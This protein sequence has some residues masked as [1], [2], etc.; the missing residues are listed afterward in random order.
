MSRIEATPAAPTAAPPH[1]SSDSLWLYALF[2]LLATAGFFYVNIMAAIVDGLVTGLGFSNAQAGI[3][4]SANIYGASVGSLIAVFI[5]RHLPWRRT[6][7]V[8]LCLLLCIDLISIAI[9][10][11]TLLTVVRALHGLI[12][13]MAVGVTYS[14]MARTRSPDRA[15][16][17]LLLMQFGLG[18]L[19]VMILPGLVPEYG[20]RVLFLVLAGVTTAALLATFAIPP[21]D[22]REKTQQKTTYP[23]LQRRS[24]LTAGFTL[25]ALFLFQGGNMA[26]AAFIIGLGEH[27]GLQRD[28]IS[29]ALGWATW[30]GAVGAILVIA[31]GTRMG[32]TLPL[33]VALLLTLIGNAGFW[34]SANQ[35]LFFAANIGTAITWSFVVPYLFGMLSRLDPSGRLATLGGFLSKLGLASGPLAAGMLL[36][37]GNYRLLIGISVAALALSAIAA[38][39]AAR[40]SDQMEYAT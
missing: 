9:E 29:Q 17:V 14:A 26:L 20:A 32:R 39:I 37:S 35:A 4:G 12:G 19:G 27:Y 5:V 31:L 38:L 24:L 33:L 1:S 2:A 15:F 7:F 13:G 36:H 10:R 28:F 40:R 18:G 8:L 21:I 3:V 25:L 22:A 30:I 23:P 34:W 6:L 11:V 16:G